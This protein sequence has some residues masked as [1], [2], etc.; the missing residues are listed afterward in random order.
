[1]IIPRPKAIKYAEYRF[2][3][4][5]ELG[6]LVSDDYG[7][8]ALHVLNVL[9]AEIDVVFSSGLNDFNDYIEFVYSNEF[10]VK[11]AYRIEFSEE[12][13][14]L[15]YGD[16]LGARNA[17]ISLAGLIERDD[18][19]F[20][21]PACHVSDYPDGDYRGILIDLAREYI[22]LEKIKTI[23]VQMAKAK[24]NK[25]HLHLHDSEHYS[26]QSDAYPELNETTI[27]QYT[28]SQLKEVV[29]YAQLFSLDIIPEIEMPAHGLFITEKLNKL[30]CKT[31][32]VPPS[33][34][35]MCVGN[36]KTY[37]I[38]ANLIKEV[39]EIFPG[40]YIHIGADELEFCDVYQEDRLWPTWDDCEVCKE[41]SQ[42]ENLEGKREQ[43]YY[44][45]RRIHGIVTGL[46]K[47]MMMWNDGID[48]SRSPNIPR[49]I[50]IQ[51]WRVA[52]EGR[53]PV[54]GCS[55]QRFLEEGFHV[56]NSD[57]PETYLDLY[58]EE[59]NIHSWNPKARPE[60]SD[61]VKHKIIGGEMCAWG[62][63]D[64]YTYT[65]PSAIH[66]FGDKLWDYT[67]IKP[68]MEYSQAI[69]KAVLGLNI[70]FQFDVFEALGGILLPRTKEG[71]EQAYTDLISEKLEHTIKILQALI[72]QHASGKD[73]AREY[74]SIIRTMVSS[75][76]R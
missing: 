29:E 49:D 5:H 21:I 8:K 38:L 36:E 42:R 43:F 41:L 34:W 53:G 31:H 68:T 76:N 65:L 25:L 1:M 46:G 62:P 7:K 3:L 16:E 67:D 14:V 72:D 27:Q 40:E 12:K 66:I 50:L 51:Y 44:F 69:T 58:M 73:A 19:G 55:M 57:Y 47:K 28:K 15:T 11:E 39:S 13:V 18:I 32:H 56:V 54:Q 26:I 9:T 75:V 17:V 74:I 23:I 33:N 37:D 2:Y 6:V 63:N 71:L 64:H 70:P 52:A 61:E 30:K 4:K 20:F 48:I 45:I 59:E 35:A 22:P 24:Y 60:T 10:E